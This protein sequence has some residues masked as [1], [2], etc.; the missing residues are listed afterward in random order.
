M[1]KWTTGRNESYMYVNVGPGD[2]VDT[3]SEA[4]CCSDDGVSLSYSAGL[5][6]SL[7][8]R[9][10]CLGVKPIRWVDYRKSSYH[11]N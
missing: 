4:V 5:S 1:D 3:G 2:S 7:F 9:L 6:Q 8:E 10:V 11:G